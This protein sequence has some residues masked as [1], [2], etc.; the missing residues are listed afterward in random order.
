MFFKYTAYFETN[1]ERQHSISISSIPGKIIIFLQG[2]L[3]GVTGGSILVWFQFAFSLP[4]TF[5]SL[6]VFQ[7]LSHSSPLLGFLCLWL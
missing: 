4:E 5:L 6:Y 7:L 1:F 2:I 3:Q